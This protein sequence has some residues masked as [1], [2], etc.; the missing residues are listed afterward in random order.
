MGRTRGRLLLVL[1]IYYSAFGQRKYL[2]CYFLPLLRFQETIVYSH[3][4]AEHPPKG[5]NFISGTSLGS[6]LSIATEVRKIDIFVKWTDFDL[7]AAG[8][9]Q[10]NAK[11]AMNTSKSSRWCAIVYWNAVDTN[12]HGSETICR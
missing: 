3:H 7:M 2:G 9:E 11:I 5:R 12:F 6:G 8:I 4:A 1:Y 10:T